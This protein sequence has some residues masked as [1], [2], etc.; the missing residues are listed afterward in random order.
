MEKGNCSNS[1]GFD[2]FF[3]LFVELLEFSLGHCFVNSAHLTFSGHREVNQVHLRGD[4]VAQ[5][6]STAAWLA[7]CCE[8]LEVAHV[9][10]LN[11]RAIVP[12][13]V[14]NPLAQ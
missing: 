9:I 5:L 4:S 11:L 8:D 12:E 1:E 13:S 14:I 2:Q 3:D 7:H 10:F 6:G